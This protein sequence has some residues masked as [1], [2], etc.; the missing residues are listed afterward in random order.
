MKS[1]L[2]VFVVS[3][4]VLGKAEAKKYYVS[5]SGSNTNSGLSQAL[6]WKTITY[7][8]S[9]SSAVVPGDTVYVKAGSYGAEKV[10]FQKSGTAVSPI[11]YIGY[12]D[13]PGDEPPLLVSSTNPY[14]VFQSSDMPLL[15]GGNRASGTAFNASNQK[16]LVLKNFQIQNYEYGIIAGGSSQVAGNLVLRNINVMSMGDIN[17]SYS[18]IGFSFGSMS[19]SFSNNNQLANCLVVNASAEGI[20]MFGDN[21]ILYGC[22][23]Y[24]NENTTDAASTDYY[25]TLCGSYNTVKNCYVERFP[26]LYHSGHGI[27]VKSNAEQIVDKGLSLP[28]INPQYNKILYCTA[29]NM[30]ESFCVRHRGTQYNL[31]YHCTGIGTHTG[32]TGSSSGEGECMVTRDG[33]SNN[34]FDGCVAEN[35]SSGFVF[36]DSV[37]DGDTG[38]NPPGHPCDNNKY[39]NCLI[40]NCYF[41]VSFSDNGVQSDAGNN[42]IANCTFY[43]VR[44]IHYAARHCANM[45]Y[46]GNIYYGCLP[47][48]SGGYFK[49]STF[50]SDIIPNGSNSYFKSCFFYNIQGGVPSG[51]I[52]VNGCTD[53][54]PVLNNP[55]NQDFHL[56]STSPCRDACSIVNVSTDFDSLS[57]LVGPS[58]DVGAFEYQTISP[59]GATISTVNVKCNSGDDGSATVSASGG[60]SP[61]AY[62]WSNGKSSALV[63]GLTAGSFMVTISDVGVNSKTYTVIITQPLVIALNIFSQTNASCN[64][65]SNGSV[66]VSASG[67]TSPYT[68]SWSNGKTTASCTGL[69]AG[70]YTVTVYDSN[71]C[72]KALVATITQPSAINV[73]TTSQTNASC[74]G[75]NNGSVTVSASGGTSPYTY[76]WSNGKTTASCTG[77]GAGSYT[78]TVYDSNG[79]WKALVATITQPSAIALSI[80]SKKNVKCNGGVNGSATIAVSGGNA[81]YS[82]SWNNGQTTAT[83]TGLS[84]GNYSVNVYDVNSCSST[85]TVTITEPPLLVLNNPSR[86][87]VSCN[88]KADGSAEVIANGGDGDYVYL[89]SPSEQTTTL[90]T[91]LLASEYTVTVTDRGGCQGKKNVNIS[92]PAPLLVDEI[93]VTNPTSCTNSDGIIRVFASG[94]NGRYSHRW[95]TSPPQ[96]SEIAFGLKIGNYSDIVIDENG[97]TS[98]GQATVTCTS[99]TGI[100]SLRKVEGELNVF[101]NPATGSF[102]INSPVQQVGKPILVV[103]RDYLGKEYYSKVIVVS[104]SEE[105]ITIDPSGVLS[106]GV[107]V[108]IATSDDKFYERKIV[109]Q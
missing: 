15:D 37:E 70:S 36:M 41:G 35:C 43:K 27:S 8:A 77:L 106:P 47:T 85:T 1:L 5:T 109:V 80:I 34:T 38:S 10:V 55:S 100:A 87:S 42:T 90:A 44:Y 72:W 26:G 31:F 19:T 59:F 74:N 105:I 66:T 20:S 63:T 12:K 24:C 9:N 53:K 107:Y 45:K 6:S 96:F 76:S 11:S 18:G 23:V 14:A 84:A 29:K 64:G 95:N 91:G 104:N 3:I 99:P 93:T 89:W 13:T 4:I 78:V 79:C 98:V 25:I 22:K 7:A 88:G 82:Y 103:V 101:P 81:P 51:F 48:S 50:S 56:K 92:Q 61:Y 75:G 60:A 16:Y 49:G 86:K 67:G 32:A 71:G 68:Y 69:G 83:C 54:D 39:V 40:K 2:L 102:N 73:N 97:C 94:G 65:G 46:I 62:S 108:V 33:A 58:V 17:S 28:V 21:N 52:G 30:G 57:R